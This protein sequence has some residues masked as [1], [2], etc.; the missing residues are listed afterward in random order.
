MEKSV[1]FLLFHILLAAIV[2]A[3]DLYIIVLLLEG[4]K[5]DI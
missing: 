2:M 4:D 3:G 5:D 1:L